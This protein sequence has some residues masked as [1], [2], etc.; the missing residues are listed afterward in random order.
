MESLLDRLSR[1]LAELKRRR[2]YRVAVVYAATAFVVVQVADLTFVRLGLPPWTV[3]LVIAL[4][5][6]GF[7]VAVVLA[8]AFEVTPEGVRRTETVAGAADA[9][10]G[11]GTVSDGPDAARAP[12]RTGTVLALAVGLTLTAVGGW[13]LSGVGDGSGPAVQRLAV[14]PLANLMDDPDQTY[15]VQGMHDRLISELQQAGVA[16]INRTSVVRYGDGETPAGQIARE[17][18]ADAL[19][20]GSVYR[21]ADSVEIEAR[22]IDPATGEYVWSGSY[23]ESLGNV[24]A[25]H[26]D[27]ARAVAG[28][29]RSVLAPEA[30]ER[31]ALEPSPVDPD[32]YDAYL[33]G[34]FH[35]QR[36]TPEDFSRALEHFQAALEMDSTYA[37]AYVG[38]AR[39]WQFRAQASGLT[40]VTAL[41][42]RRHIGPAL[43]RAL[44]LDPSLAEA[45]LGVAWAKTWN[46]WKFDA[47]RAA[48]ER[49]IELNPAHAE[50]RVF[51]GHL[52]AI[53][54]RWE[55]A[56]EQGER[57]MELDPLN[58]FIQGLYAVVLN[59]T[60]RHEEAIEVLEE[61][62]RENPGAGFGRFPLLL[63]Y[64]K[65]ERYE[66]AL[67]VR[68][69]IA[70][71]RD[72]PEVVVALERGYRE[73]GYREALRRVVELRASRTPDGELPPRCS[74]NL[75]LKADLPERALDC[76]ERDIES[77]GQNVPYA[78]VSPAWEPY[79]DHPRYRELVRRIGV[80]VIS[81]PTAGS[82]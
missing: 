52:L 78:G 14:L 65:A 56:R 38:V 72:E 75:Y 69:E 79:H 22:L 40:G 68:K 8:W 19:V 18:D 4:A 51:Y 61:M 48:F 74:R 49:A 16:V 36:F 58:P 17:L 6:L 30:E 11:P 73:G 23:G 71:V 32:A 27:L 15:F 59:L 76:L 62:F 81:A 67:R 55:E 33:R 2:V 50:A 24:T 43:E 41:E 7:P 70:R 12:V 64:E 25:L 44:E 31:L 47:G 60:R 9:P 1:F 26:R 82:S 66:D 20:E 77:H 35:A 21:V 29:I 39:V 42:A 53:L 28:E 34:V 5:L 57:A 63:S 45:H 13:W 54:G 3:T 37:P 80:P 10:E 46:E